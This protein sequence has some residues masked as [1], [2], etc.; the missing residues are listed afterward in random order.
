M[1]KTFLM[2]LGLGA[3]FAV[4]TACFGPSSRADK[5]SPAY[6]S[7]NSPAGPR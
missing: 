7:T 1:K 5:N 6:S 4:G 3:V 2:L